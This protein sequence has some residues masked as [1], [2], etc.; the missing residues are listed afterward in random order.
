MDYSTA[1]LLDILM[2]IFF[3]YLYI[4]IKR[5]MIKE[6]RS[7]LVIKS[8]SLIFIAYTW[9]VFNIL[10]FLICES[11]DELTTLS[12]LFIISTFSIGIYFYLILSFQ[13]IYT[14]YKLGKEKIKSEYHKFAIRLLY[15]YIILAFSEIIWI[16]FQL[17]H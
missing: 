11:R 9:L 17:Q 16:A 1:I 3:I 4:Q 14:A 5:K 8:Y 12:Y 6:K 15:S 2:V 13:M 10:P 7:K